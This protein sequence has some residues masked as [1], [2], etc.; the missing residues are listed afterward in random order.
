ME[1]RQLLRSAQVGG[2]P[3]AR[4]EMGVYDL[5]LTRG[6]HLGPWIGEEI[7]L[8]GEGPAIEVTPLSTLNTRPHRRA[9]ADP[10]LLPGY[11]P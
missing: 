1:T 7:E 4:L 6:H 2:L 9:S 5:L 11:A 3:D 8:M 10:P